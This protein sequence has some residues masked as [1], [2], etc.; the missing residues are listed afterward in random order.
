MNVVLRSLTLADAENVAAAMNNEK[1]LANLRDGIPF[2][3]T[4]TDAEEYI[5]Y[6]LGA[7][8]NAVFAFAVGVDGKAAGIISAFRQNNI[9]YRTAELGYFIGEEYWGKGVMTRAVKLACGYLF[10]NTDLLRVYAEPFATN[11]ASCRVLAKAGFSFEG[12]LVSN[13]YKNGKV[14]DMKIYALVREEECAEDEEE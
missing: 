14:L 1:V 3:Y 6:L 7:D 8:K 4:L 10:D 5:S 11:H 9:H 13:A 12:V 2:P